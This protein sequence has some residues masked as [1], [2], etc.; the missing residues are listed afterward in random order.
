MVS[1]FVGCQNPVALTT[2]CPPEATVTAFAPIP[3]N[4]R[5][6]DPRTSSDPPLTA[7]PPVSPGLVVVNISDPL[8]DLISPPVAL[9]MPDTCTVPLWMF[10]R[11][12]PVTDRLA[13]IFCMLPKVGDTLT[14][15]MPVPS[16]LLSVM[17]FVG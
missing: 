16:P 1:V 11:K 17:V 12:V 14:D 5:L 9:T 3:L 15:R 8:P 7:M 10:A 4:D 6:S 2:N 13:G